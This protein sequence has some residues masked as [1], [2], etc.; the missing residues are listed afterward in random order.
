MEYETDKQPGVWERLKDSPRTVSALIIILVVAAA[1]Y[2]FSGDTDQEQQGEAE[3]SEVTSEE[4]AA[5]SPPAPV[6]RET[7]TEQSQELPAA[8]TTE[9]GY[10]EVAQ[11]G[12]GMTHLARRAA[13][14][15][16]SENT[17]SYN[18]T[19]EHRIFL[20]DYIQ[21]KMGSP[22]L[23]LDE[24]QTIS[25]DLIKEAIE[26]AGNLTPRQLNNLSQYTY[27]LD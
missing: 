17:P 15:Y 20:E 1:I 8:T 10:G 6:A 27:V 23:T 21:K 9:D 7:L 25:F 14:R 12:D 2:A 4:Q 26:A 11:A 18:V 5:V 3:Q 24:S 22:R 13:T 16:L 19:N